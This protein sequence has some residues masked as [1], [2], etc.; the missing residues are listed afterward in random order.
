MF[1]S[2]FSELGWWHLAQY[3]RFLDYKNINSQISH[4]EDTHPALACRNVILSPLAESE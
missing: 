3:S 2:H 1:A 4:L